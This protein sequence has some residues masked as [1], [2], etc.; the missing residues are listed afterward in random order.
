V[1]TASARTSNASGI[2]T[3]SFLAVASHDPLYDENLAFAARLG[4]AGAAV[5]LIVYPGTIHGFL[6]AAAA[7]EAPVALR[8][9]RDIGRFLA[10]ALG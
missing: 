6:E 9:V 1:S 2:V 3:P 8:A 5:E 10:G 7:V 4:S